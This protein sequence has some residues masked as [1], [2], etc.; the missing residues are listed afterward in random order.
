MKNQVVTRPARAE[1]KSAILTFCRNTFSWGDYIPDVWD[2]W[3]AD[4]DG[5]I[6]VGVLDRQPVGMVHVALLDGGVGWMEGLRVHPDFRRRGVGRAIDT[7]A[8]AFA[9]ERGCHLAR[10]STSIRNVAAHQLLA[11][12]GYVRLAQFG[13]W[14]AK[15][16]RRRFAD[17]RIA[18]RTDA[19]AIL[20]RWRESSMRPALLANRHWQWVALTE[21]NVHE[22]A[23]AGEIRVM[24]C[25]FSILRAFDED[26]WSGLILHALVGDAETMRAL[27]LA[28]RGEAKYRGYPHVEAM[29]IEC[30]PLNATLESAGYRRD[31]G[32][33]IYEQGL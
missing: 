17:A 2:R 3:L 32:M 14:N 33:F 24:P 7:V 13:E 20:A 25:G 4:P 15:P 27:A 28:A 1:D 23:D 31:G 9:R 30:P 12:Q 26:D 18:T 19:C 6:R 8:R 11:A 10:L 22:Q 5:Q 29:L 21:V 16:A